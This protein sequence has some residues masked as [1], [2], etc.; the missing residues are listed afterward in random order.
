MTRTIKSWNPP[1]D[2]WWWLYWQNVAPRDSLPSPSRLL[3]RHTHTQKEKREG[4][5]AACSLKV[6]IKQEKERERK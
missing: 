2:G 6:A 4:D 1:N 5:T 3:H